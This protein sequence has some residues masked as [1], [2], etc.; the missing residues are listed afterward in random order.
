MSRDPA[1]RWL[2]LRDHL[3]ATGGFADAPPA[4]MTTRRFL[5]VGDGSRADGA[6]LQHDRSR[7]HGVEEPALDEDRARCRPVG[8]HRD[9]D[10]GGPDDLEIQDLPDPV[11]APGR[12]IVRVRAC[13]LNHLDLF[14]VE[15]LPGVVVSIVT[16]T[17]VE[18]DDPAFDSPSKPVGEV[19][20]PSRAD[21]A[22]AQG[23]VLAEDHHRHGFRRV[24]ASPD[25]KE[26]V[27]AGAIESLY[28]KLSI[29]ATRLGN[30][31]SE[32]RAFASRQV[33]LSIAATVWLFIY[34]AGAPDGRPD[35]P[36][37]LL[38]VPAVVLFVVEVFDQAEYKEEQGKHQPNSQKQNLYT[39]TSRSW[40]EVYI[41]SWAN[42]MVL[43][44]ILHRHVTHRHTRVENPI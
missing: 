17:L 24:V 23:W 1:A 20:D 38:M 29:L 13:A 28:G 27:E 2:G 18:A 41:K 12:A 36:N 35:A 3:D 42:Q 33:W 8:E 30:L 44:I 40:S 10:V 39:N 25:P 34:G 37:G 26:I 19:I 7:A 9:H 32:L 6:H 15:G 14:V 4:A 31:R 5:L 16:Q 11:P 43:S 22:R 21:D